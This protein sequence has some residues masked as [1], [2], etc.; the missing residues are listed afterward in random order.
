SLAPANAAGECT[1]TDTGN[2]YVYECD[3]GPYTS[4]TYGTTATSPAESSSFQF[5]GTE[6]TGDSSQPG[7]VFISTNEAGH[8]VDILIQEDDAAQEPA[9]TGIA[10]DLNV[11]SSAFFTQTTNGQSPITLV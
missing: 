6:A 11:R 7:A 9:F 4:I 5:S 2:P 3:A 1:L 10:A 8:S